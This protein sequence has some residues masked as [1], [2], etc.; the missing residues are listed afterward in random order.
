M[1]D[2]K[3]LTTRDLNRRTAGV[4]DELER[5]ETFELRRHGK[6]VGYLTPTP[7]L[8][9]HKPDWKSHFDWL[10][11]QSAKTDAEILGEFEEERRRQAGRE[12]AMGNPK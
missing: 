10:R 3:T 7:P 8:P 2:M 6:A 5:G 4:L 12:Q 1:S 9:Q 11:K